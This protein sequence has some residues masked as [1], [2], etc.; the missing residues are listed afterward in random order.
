MIFEMRTDHQRLDARDVTSKY[1]LNDK[2][3]IKEL[4]KKK[5]WILF[6]AVVQVNIHENGKMKVRIQNKV[7]SEIHVQ[8]IFQSLDQEEIVEI[9]LIDRKK[10]GIDLNHKIKQMMKIIY[11]IDDII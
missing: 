6:T 2:F 8:K 7:Y 5:N 9:E 1:F 4:M 3:L 11:R 10:N